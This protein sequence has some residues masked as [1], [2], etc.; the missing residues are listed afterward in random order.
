MFVFFNVQLD[1]N[2]D[3]HTLK[4]CQKKINGNSFHNFFTKRK[5]FLANL[6]IKT[7]LR[8]RVNHNANN[9]LEFERHL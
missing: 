1:S 3:K 5:P 9:I 7:Y 4:V 2:L 8:S 6:G